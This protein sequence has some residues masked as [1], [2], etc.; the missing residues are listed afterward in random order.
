[1]DDA[2]T[3]DAP[4]AWSQ[5]RTLYGGITAALCAAAA[6]RAIPDL[7]PLRGAQLAFVG[8]AS[9]MVRFVPRVLR[10]GRS[11]TF[12]GVD[13]TG[14]SGAA[15]RALFLYG[16]DRESEV[17]HDVTAMPA[18]A[19]PEACRPLFPDGA[20]PPTFFQNFEVRFVSGTPP[21]T[22]AERP[23][24]DVWVRHR[25]A[26]DV[27]PVIA[28]LALAD[29]LPPAAM[30]GFS[31]PAPI[32]TMTWSVDFFHPVPATGWHLLRS[33][34]EQA[35]HGLSLQAMEL[36]DIDGRRLAVGR[37]TVAMFR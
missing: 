8:P 4:Q 28:L 10:R 25:D 17:A 12:V 13:A 5:G 31:A 32:S 26:A 30:A 6:A 23:T 15:A 21:V 18:A 9:G 11:A 36:W 33:T 35:A 7:A 2:F 16:V 20:V 14:D 19:A 37:Q 3:I 22:R 1:M 34:S 29:C 27:D 24:F